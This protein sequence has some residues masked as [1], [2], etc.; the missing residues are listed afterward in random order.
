YGGAETGATPQNASDPEILAISLPAQI[1]QFQTEVR[2]PS[3]NALYTLSI[4]SNDLLEILGATGLS[5]QQQTTD[6]NNA[7]ANEISFVKQL[8]SDGAK[9]LLVLNVPDLGKTPDVMQGLVNGSNTPSAALDA[10]A[11]QLASEYNSALTSQLG[12]LATAD[13][14]NVHVVDAYSLI[15]DAIADPA[16]YGFTNVTSPVWSGSYTSSSSGTLAVTGAAAQDQYLF[17][18]HLHPTEAG[19]Q[20]IADAAEEEL[21]G[22]SVIAVEDT[23]TG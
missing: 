9:N 12:T 7:V 1:V 22:T 21:S 23:T 5:A 15:D 10:E 6:V 17:W 18:D 8:V 3:A 11:S 2:T 14:L 20:A 13:T 19:H 16:A 4:G